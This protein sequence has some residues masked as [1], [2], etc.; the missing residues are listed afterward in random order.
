MSIIFGGFEYIT[1]LRIFHLA[2]L[3]EESGWA[4]Y[5]FHLL[6]E[7]TNLGDLFKLIILH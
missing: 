6:G 2:I 5:F 4:R 1:I 7:T 3:L